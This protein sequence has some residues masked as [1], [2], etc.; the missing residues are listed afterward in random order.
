MSTVPIVTVT[1]LRDIGLLE[2]Q[3][4]SIN[5]Y[6][7]KQTP[8]YII[9]N[10]NHTTDWFLYFE[11][12]I[13]PYYKNH[14]L[15]ILS[16]K[17][18]TI[19]IN[20]ELE[21]NTQQILKLVI[22]NEIY[23]DYYLVLDSK[24][25]LTK[26]FDPASLLTNNLAPMWFN[27]KVLPVETYQHYAT[28]LDV[29]I[30]NSYEEPIIYTP[31]YLNTRLVKSLMDNFGSQNNFI[32][33]FLKATNI[34]SEFILYCIWAKK[35]GGIFKFHY[36]KPN[37]D[38][39]VSWWNDSMFTFLNNLKTRPWGSIHWKNW[40]AFDNK[41]YQLIVSELAHYDLILPD[42]DNIIK[43]LSNDYYLSYK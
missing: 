10:E 26:H 39:L 22:A 29:D 5:L 28:E 20:N 25:F 32:K 40:C 12:K 1:C 33:W 36:K 2:L 42:S 15:R 31:F 24:N 16:K 19:D 4:Q 23:Q 27:Y 41:S 13:K 21:W 3:A 7:S 34:K 8:I 37:A 43:K 18:F 9:I 6:L 14:D 30:A 11:Q 38:Y 17:D 35:Q